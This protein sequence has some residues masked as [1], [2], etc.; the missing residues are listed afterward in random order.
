MLAGAAPLDAAAHERFFDA[1]QAGLRSAEQAD[2]SGVPVA[3]VVPISR[4]RLWRDSRW[5]RTALIAAPLV[6]LAAAA[7]LVLLPAGPRLPPYAIEITAGSRTI[8]SGSSEPRAEVRVTL[9]QGERFAAVLRPATPVAEE[10]AAKGWL[11]SGGEGAPWSPTIRVS[12]SGAVRLTGGVD[13][14]FAGRV[15]VSE[16]VV[17][18]GVSDRLPAAFEDVGDRTSADGWQALRATVVVSAAPE[19]DREERDPDGA[20]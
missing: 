14:L 17:V 9:G 11:V 3:E 16:L 4:H 8:R 15:G 13:T 1:A 10:V 6:A 19:R 7:V 18:V 20:P 5:R 2:V 12:D